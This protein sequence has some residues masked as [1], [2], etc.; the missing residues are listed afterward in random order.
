MTFCQVKNPPVLFLCKRRCFD[1]MLPGKSFDVNV[2]TRESCFPIV[3]CRE[4]S[5]TTQAMKQAI[6]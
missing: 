1:D 4:I 5:E 2:N 3:Y 6:S